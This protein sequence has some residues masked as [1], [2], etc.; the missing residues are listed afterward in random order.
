MEVSFLNIYRFLVKR[1]QGFSSPAHAALFLITLSLPGAFSGHRPPPG[2]SSIHA[3]SFTALG[4]S[5]FILLNS[6]LACNGI[7]GAGVQREN[8]EG[9]PDNHLL[10]AGGGLK[11]REKRVG[12]LFFFAWPGVKDFADFSPACFFTWPGADPLP[13][14]LPSCSSVSSSCW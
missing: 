9:I 6:S 8:E 7:K 13:L 4:C 3:T 12:Y 11:K 10:S 1:D 5:S 2:S 14:L